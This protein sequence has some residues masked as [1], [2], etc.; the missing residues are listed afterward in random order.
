MIDVFFSG[1]T[2]CRAKIG[3]PKDV[4]TI[5]NYLTL[6]YNQVHYAIFFKTIWG[7]ACRHRAVAC[8]VLSD[9]LFPRARGAADSRRRCSC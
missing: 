7:S 6:A 3:G 5:K 9:R 8:R 2:S 4:Y 1:P